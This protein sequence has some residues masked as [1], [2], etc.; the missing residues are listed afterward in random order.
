MAD[1]RPAQKRDIDDL[2]DMINRR[3]DKQDK[4]ILKIE[5]KAD[6][7]SAKVDDES[8]MNVQQ[9]VRIDAIEQKLSGYAKWIAGVF[10]SVVVLAIKAIWDANAGT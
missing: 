8:K 2:R 6:K 10:A 4:E 1:N 3:F 7:I 9:E 5:V